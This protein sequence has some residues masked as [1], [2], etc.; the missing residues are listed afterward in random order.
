M[1]PWWGSVLLALFTLFG[2]WGLRTLTDR[3]DK[4]RSRDQ[5][6]AQQELLEE[7]GK[8]IS[9]L[10]HAFEVL[11]QRFGDLASAVQNQV[12][13]DKIQTIRGD[14][15]ASVRPYLTASLPAATS[16]G[17]MSII[18]GPS[19]QAIPSGGDTR[20]GYFVPHP[21]GPLDIQPTEHL[22]ETQRQELEGNNKEK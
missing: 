18:L 8:Q 12:K 3:G 21:G 20:K 16:Q 1:M 5:I 19:G 17:L 7:Q 4:K 15:A 10:T 11:A 2:G 13:P 14:T 22:S 6:A 9:N